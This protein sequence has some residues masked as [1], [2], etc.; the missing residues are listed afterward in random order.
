MMIMI[1]YTTLDNCA[2]KSRNGVN[3]TVKE[4]LLY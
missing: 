2:S 4:D 3:T 1:A